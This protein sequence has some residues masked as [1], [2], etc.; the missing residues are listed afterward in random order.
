MIYFSLI[1]F[2]KLYADFFLPSDEIYKLDRNPD[3]VS[4]VCYSPSYLQKHFGTISQEK[5]IKQIFPFH[6]FDI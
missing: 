6:Y 3:C 1:E 2:F 4:L 5:Y